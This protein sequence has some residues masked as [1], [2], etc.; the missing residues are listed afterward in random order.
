MEKRREVMKRIIKW[1]WNLVLQRAGLPM[2]DVNIIFPEMITQDSAQKMK[3]ILLAEQARWI[4]P[5]RAATMAAKELGISNFS[6]VEELKDIET[7]LPEIP[8]PLAD[9]AQQNPPSSMDPAINTIK[10]P[11]GEGA[12]P[13]SS[14]LTGSEK[15][16]VKQNDSTL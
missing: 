9:P 11:E 12:G 3:N 7:Q 6:Y 5:E 1:A 16:E 13:G 14:G 8:M 10:S 4:K 2:V 15:A